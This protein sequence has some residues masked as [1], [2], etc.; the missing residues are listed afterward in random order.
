VPLAAS[1]YP[2]KQTERLLG[3]RSHMTIAIGFVCHGGVIVAADTKIAIG[4]AAQKASKLHLFKAK[5]GP[6]A[7]AFASEDA[8]ATRTLLNRIQRRLGAN[9]CADSIELEKFV[10]DEMT[11]WRSAY[12]IN[13]PGMQL[14]VACRLNAEAPRLFFCEPPNTFLE[15]EGYVAAGTG[16]DVT[17]PLHSTLFGNSSIAPDVQYGLRQ[18]AYLMYRAKEDNIFCG[19]STYC[20]VVSWRCNPL[21][22]IVNSLDFEVAERY[23]TELDFLLRMTSS[24]YLGGD[25]AK[26]KENAKGVADSFEGLATLRTLKFHGLD[27]KIILL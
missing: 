17:D 25:E 24:L 6:F 4:A 18:V 16:A 3:K 26:V 21:P 1:Y 9:D 20:A 12:T 5:A 22:E 19:K 27:G 11:N 13:P 10:C 23:G 14:V 15:H 7:I 2:L 8:N